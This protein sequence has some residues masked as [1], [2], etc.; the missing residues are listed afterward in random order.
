VDRPRRGSVEREV[1]GDLAEDRSQRQAVAA[2][3]RHEDEAVGAGLVVDDR[4]AVG[5]DVEQARPV[6]RD[7]QS[8]Q[9]GHHAL[10]GSQRGVGVRAVGGRRLG[11]DGDV[12]G[13]QARA[14]ADLAQRERRI[15]AQPD[16]AAIALVAR[17]PQP[18]VARGR[19]REPTLDAR[20]DPG[21]EHDAPVGTLAAAESERPDR[22]AEAQIGRL[23]LRLPV[24]DRHERDLDPDG[25]DQVRRPDAAG[26]DDGAGLDV[27]AARPHA[28]HAAVALDDRPRERAA[29]GPDAANLR[30]LG[31]RPRRL[32]RI[33]LPVVLAPHGRGEGAGRERQHLLCVFPAEE[34]DVGEPGAVRVRDQLAQRRQL[35]RVVA[36]VDV[37]AEPQLAVDLVSELLPALD[38]LLCERELRGIAALQAQRALRATR[39]L[40]ARLLLLLDQDHLRAAR[41][42][43]GRAG[44]A[45]DPAADDDDVR[46]H[47]GHEVTVVASCRSIAATASSSTST[48]RPGA[49][50]TASRLSAIAGGGHVICRSYLRGPIR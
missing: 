27:A 24:R 33:A 3:S 46:R 7:P 44:V 26:H 32:R 9:R 45:R 20:V 25:A 35:I 28:A 12:V 21:A 39:A 41:R 6:L 30:A 34:T 37:A 2:Q 16:V 18:D 47:G 5:G 10:Q 42:R 19:E 8:I 15:E 40:P 29:Q 22:G 4:Q 23:R 31:E 48:P 43:A 1:G 17:R 36:E 13:R 14:V 38:R 49:S 50:P 11:R